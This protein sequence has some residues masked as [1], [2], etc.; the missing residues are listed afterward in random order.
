MID[1]MG[2]ALGMVIIFIAAV[3]FFSGMITN[4]VAY[5]TQRNY[6]LNAQ[7]LFDYILLGTGS[8]S[9]WGYTTS[10]PTAFGLAQPGASEYTLNPGAVLRL[11]PMSPINIG[12]RTY[13]YLNLGGVSL[14]EPPNYYVNYT[15]AKQLLGISGSY[16]FQLTLTP[17]LNVTVKPISN[18]KFLV[19]ATGYGGAPMPNAQVTAQYVYAISS[20]NGK[21]NNNLNVGVYTDS[22][23]TNTTGEAVIS[24]PTQ[25]SSTYYL[26]VQVSAAGIYGA[27]Y[28][29]NN[30]IGYALANI[31]V[32]PGSSYVNLTQHCVSSITPPCGVDNYNV[33]LLIPSG[34][35]YSLY[36]VCA[37]PSSTQGQGTCLNAGGGS[38]NTHSSVSCPGSFYDGYIAV[39]ISKRGAS[40]PQQLLLVPISPP[41]FDLKL[42]YGY[43]P[44]GSSSSVTLTRIVEISGIS[45]VAQLAYWP[46]VGPVFGGY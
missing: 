10:Q 18:S 19:T 46:D 4:G 15:Y 35:S 8:P 26:L 27:G 43:N 38:G 22:A 40:S 25:S 29:T 13:Y 36:E 3:F 5:S 16:E 1:Y 6:A 21:G 42:T 2:A 33:T 17:A 45:Y 14:I 11:M 41:L 34:N 12:G 20:G 37:C 28:Y 7:N 23:T 39:A 30:Q 9:N 44:H 32:Y 31:S 24:F